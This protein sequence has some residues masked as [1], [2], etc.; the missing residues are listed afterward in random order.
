MF[1]G[2]ARIEYRI[3]HAHS[4]KAKRHVLRKLL[5]RVR[6]K[7]KVSVNEVDFL[8]KWQRTALGVAVVGGDGSHVERM[9]SQIMDYLDEQHLAEPL[10]RRSEVIQ[11]DDFEEFGDFEGLDDFGGFEDQIPGGRDG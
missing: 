7:F 11:F 1:V 4:L 9:L 2:I 5:D 8:D 6:A 3:P 10:G